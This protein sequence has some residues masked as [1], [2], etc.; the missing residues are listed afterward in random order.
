MCMG[1][2]AGLRNRSTQVRN[3]VA[4]LR[5]NT[6]GDDMNYFILA[7]LGLIVPLLSL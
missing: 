6:L 2:S 5:T 4:Q 7:A 1:Q 3:P